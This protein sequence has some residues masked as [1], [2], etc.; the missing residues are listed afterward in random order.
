MYKDKTFI[1]IIPARGGSKSVP[2][3]NIQMVGGKPLVAWSILDSLCSKYVDR[4]IV[5]T[6]DGEIARISKDYGATVIPRP[7]ELAQDNTQTEPVMLQVLE[8]IE[9]DY[10]VLLEPT[11][12][13]RRK[14]DIDNAIKKIVDEGADSLLSVYENDVFYWKK[15]A[16]SVACVVKASESC[17]AVDVVK[18]V[19]PT[20]SDEQE[21]KLKDVYICMKCRRESKYF[22]KCPSC[23]STMI[24]QTRVEKGVLGVRS[25]NYDFRDRPRRQEKEWEWVENDALFITKVELLQKEKCRLGGNVVL[26]EMPQFISCEIDTVWDLK[27]ANWL[28]QQKEVLEELKK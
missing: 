5:S 22:R 18:L 4:T 15:G 1:S 20:G 9:C 23:G 19:V 17:D 6:E 25:L 14:T 26:Y 12:I 24:L 28:I 2:R 7:H 11:G 27:I 8:T 13:F 21:K 16:E 10:V 3:K